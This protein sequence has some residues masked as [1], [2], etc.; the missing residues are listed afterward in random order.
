MNSYKVDFTICRTTSWIKILISIRILELKITPAKPCAAV[1]TLWEIVI[2][3]AEMP[4]E[5][6]NQVAIL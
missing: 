1:D 6:E 4:M 2:S 5:R 3:Q